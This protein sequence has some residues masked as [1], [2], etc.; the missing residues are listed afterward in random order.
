MIPNSEEFEV[1]V[2]EG[3]LVEVWRG[4]H[5]SV[6]QQ[7]GVD[8]DGPAHSAVNSTVFSMPNACLPAALAARVRRIRVRRLLSR[9][10]KRALA[11]LVAACFVGALVAVLVLRWV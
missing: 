3:A 9:K 2:T 10:R 11:W 1:F 8:W 7:F 4:H 6:A 5:I